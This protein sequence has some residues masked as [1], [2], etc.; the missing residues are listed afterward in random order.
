MTESSGLLVRV[1][2]R[3]GAVIRFS[4]DQR[5]LEARQG[6]TVLTAMLLH[7]TRLRTFEFGDTA[8]AGFC[9]MGACQ[10]C[11]VRLADGG[12]VRACTTLVVEGMAIE[13]TS[14]LHV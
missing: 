7:G 12:R 11:W 9:L 13:T 5:T 3:A 2:P 6:D 10:D 8:R 1:K 14:T 4:V